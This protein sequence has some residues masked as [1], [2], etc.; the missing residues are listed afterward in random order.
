V[1]NGGVLS[2]IADAGSI[3]MAHPKS[4]GQTDLLGGVEAAPPNDTFA[5]S[6]F[7][8]TKTHTEFRGFRIQAKPLNTEK[9][10]FTLKEIELFI[11]M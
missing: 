8:V 9:L 6:A 10:E 11:A 2:Q 4:P 1:A 5:G 7:N 3:A